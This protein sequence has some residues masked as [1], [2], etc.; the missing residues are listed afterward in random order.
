MAIVNKLLKTDVDM[1]FPL[2]LK[3]R[4]IETSVASIRE[5]GVASD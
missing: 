5:K 4:E 1:N 2:G 3:K